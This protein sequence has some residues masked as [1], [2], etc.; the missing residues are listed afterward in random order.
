LT[1]GN[2]LKDK[3]RDLKDKYPEK[4]I[5]IRGQGLFIGVDLVK[6]GNPDSPD[7]VLAKFVIN[8]CRKLGVLI[9]TD[10]PYNNVLKIKPP[11]I[12]N[13][14]DSDVLVSSLDQSLD[15]YK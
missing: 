4:I 1:I 15:S 3:L 9:S 5:E 10:G 12:F 8:Y 6:D 14:N 7:D 2:Y 11:I 13:K